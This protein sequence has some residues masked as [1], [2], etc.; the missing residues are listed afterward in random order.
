MT[1]QRKKEITEA[2]PTDL[3]DFAEMVLQLDVPAGATPADMIAQ[4]STAWPATYIFVDEAELETPGE[5]QNDATRAQA[6]ISL[7]S[8]DAK[9]DP[10]W[11]IKIAATELPGGRDP[12]PVGVNF[13]P[14]VIQ[15]NMIADVPH[16]YI[17]ALQNAVR[18]GVTQDP[19]TREMIESG[20]MAYPF[21]VIERPDRAEIE[22]HRLRTKDLVLA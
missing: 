2:S 4:I 20:T 17:G 1:T 19:D 22:A 14:V 13:R 15:R 7:M 18:V 21:E 6:Q 11:R 9:N 16:R 3:R 8:G 12:V 10:V 5:T